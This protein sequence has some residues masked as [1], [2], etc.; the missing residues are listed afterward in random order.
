MFLHWKYICY[1]NISLSTTT[2]ADTGFALLEV[3]PHQSAL[4]INKKHILIAFKSSYAVYQELLKSMFIKTHCPIQVLRSVSPL[5]SSCP[6][7][8]KG[9]IQKQNFLTDTVPLGERVRKKWKIFSQGN[10]NQTRAWSWQ[11]A[12]TLHR[13]F[14]WW[15]KKIIFLAWNKIS[16]IYGPKTWLN[17]TPHH[18]RFFRF[19][20]FQIVKYCIGG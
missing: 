6:P 20:S 13:H 18:L 8:M 1:F 11:I 7:N 2:D 14:S 3:Q 9:E 16:S 15:N 5:L 4:K 19:F 10:Q 17:K 12:N